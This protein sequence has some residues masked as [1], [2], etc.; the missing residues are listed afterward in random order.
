MKKA[1]KVYEFDFVKR[2]TISPIILETADYASAIAK[3]TELAK[4][5]CE[6]EYPAE[7]EMEGAI[8]VAGE[9]DFGAVVI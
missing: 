9:G 8:G 1:Y 6:G 7:I 4:Q 2:E 3:A 5:W